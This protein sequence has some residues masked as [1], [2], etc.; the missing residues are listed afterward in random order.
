MRCLYIQPH[1]AMP[2]VTAFLIALLILTA[3]T[4]ALVKTWIYCRIFHKA[5]FS[6][7][8]GLLILVPI[9]NIILPFVLALGDWLIQKQLRV[10]KDQIPAPTPDTPPTQS[11][12]LS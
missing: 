4:I 12:D 2:L 7:A 9:A 11:G 3:L 10:L 1:E 6:W 8:L 5:G